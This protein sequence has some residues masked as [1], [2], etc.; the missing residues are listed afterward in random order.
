VVVLLRNIAQKTI[1]S[2]FFFQESSRVFCFAIFEYL[3][4]LT[5]TTT[6]KEKNKDGKN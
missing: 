6:T 5:N 4:N 3:N 1:F 2:T